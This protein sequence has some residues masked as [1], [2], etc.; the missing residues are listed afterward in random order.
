VN[1][2]PPSLDFDP[3]SQLT[4][5]EHG[6]LSNS[7]L[8]PKGD[9]LRHLLH[10]LKPTSGLGSIMHE[11]AQLALPTRAWR[12]V[13]GMSFEKLNESFLLNFSVE[14]RRHEGRPPKLIVLNPWKGK[15]A[16]LD[17]ECFR[18]AS[19]TEFIERLSKELNDDLI[20]LCFRTIHEI[21]LS[22]ESSLA[23][24]YPQEYISIF[25]GVMDIAMPKTIDL[26]SITI[27][28]SKAKAPNTEV[29]DAAQVV[30][31]RF[32]TKLRNGRVKDR[33]LLKGIVE[34]IK[35]QTEF[36]QDDP[37]WRVMS[38]LF[39]RTKP[40][41][42]H[43]RHKFTTPSKQVKLTTLE[44][45]AGEIAKMG[46]VI[47]EVV[48]AGSN[49]APVIVSTNQRK[50]VS[51]FYRTLSETEFP[52]EFVEKFRLERVTNVR[53]FHVRHPSVYT[54]Y[55]ELDGAP[56]TQI[57]DLVASGKRIKRC[58]L[59][60]SGRRAACV[61]L[62]TL[63]DLRRDA[64][65]V[66]VR[67]TKSKRQNGGW[68][69][70]AHLWPDIEIAHLGLFLEATSDL[71]DSYQLMQVCQ[72]GWSPRHSNPKGRVDKN[73]PYTKANVDLAQQTMR[74]GL[75]PGRDIS[76]HAGRVNFVTFWTLR[77]WGVQ[78]P[79]L[80]DTP[81]YHKLSSHFWFR[82][83]GFD[84]IGGVLNGAF[85]LHKEILRKILGLSSIDQLIRTYNRGWP[86][87]F[88]VWADI[89]PHFRD[90]FAGIDNFDILAS[91]S[92]PFLPDKFVTSQHS[93]GLHQA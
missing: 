62:M 25:N 55:Y 93:K 56:P 39:R 86:L 33:H 6:H 46:R 80:L 43:P 64:D 77:V 20:P 8:K 87:E 75:I 23:G 68:I 54:R 67:Y 38:M 13:R 34:A 36:N 61:A 41:R 12:E 24:S 88:R 71:P 69:P 47:Q 40:T 3:I 74:R 30:I 37:N 19:D 32:L 76:T 53:D 63:G 48:R 66:F 4:A 81:L 18:S 14:R 42:T 90:R 9:R 44:R 83:E 28:K 79:F 27:P 51:L 7:D 82:A 35:R 17:H 85:H 60:Y 50:I 1:I 58:N 70:I 45:Q 5:G 11:G 21:F 78:Y 92:V 16:R 10:L 84:K 2:F 26:D 91:P 72:M 52:D 31:N 49:A 59:F 73:L 15:I 89:L 65:F 22:L 57:T 29:E